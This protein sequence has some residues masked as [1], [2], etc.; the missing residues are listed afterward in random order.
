M[1][2]DAAAG[3]RA[4]AEGL[5]EFSGFQPQAELPQWYAQGDV[6]FFPTL[7]DGFPVVLAQALS[8]GLPLLTTQIVLLQIW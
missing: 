6:F 4:Q 1:L 8:G 5:I 3:V 7:E 2:P